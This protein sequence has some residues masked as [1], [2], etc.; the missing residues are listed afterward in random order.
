MVAVWVTN[1]PKY[2]R[3]VTEKLFPSWGLKH[4]ATWYWLKVTTAGEPVVPLD[5]PHRKPYEQL[6]LGTSDTEFEIP[7]QRAIVSV[8]CRRHSRKPFLQGSNI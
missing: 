3:F 1:K 5:S 6:I 7:K 2:H 8:P 4:A